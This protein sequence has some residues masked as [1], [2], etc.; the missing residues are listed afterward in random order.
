MTTTAEVADSAPG[1]PRAFR[2]AICG[3]DGSPE[4]AVAAK[5]ATRLLEAGAHLLLLDAIDPWDVI[6]SAHGDIDGTRAL[7]IEDA[8][9]TLLETRRELGE[10]LDLD[11][12]AGQGSPLDLLLAEISRE[13]TDL[14]A[15][16]YH[17]LGR[18][19]GFVSGSIATDP[20]SQSTLLRA[21]RPPVGCAPFVAI[22]DRHRHRRLDE[23]NPCAASRPQ[24]RE[25]TRCR[26]PAGDGNRRQTPR[27][28]SRG[29][30]GQRIPSP[31]RPATIRA[32]ARR[33]IQ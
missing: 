22:P 8:E 5:Q 15:V 24:P 29:E 18:M 10:P 31:T 25:S 2:R 13:R 9:G 7:L 6:L 20:A 4:A 14:V 1:S 21:S 12:R 27:P 28:A 11:G 23:L 17:G 16:G 33:A 3:I 19:H 30:A 26:P 32:C